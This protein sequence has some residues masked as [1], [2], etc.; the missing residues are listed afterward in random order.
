MET[1]D[2]GPADSARGDKGKEGDDLSKVIAT[3]PATSRDMWQ[4]I[5]TELQALGVP[6]STLQRLVR[7]VA[8][9]DQLLKLIALLTD[10]L[11][12]ASR[13]ATIECERTA[14]KEEALRSTIDRLQ[15]IVA[16]YTRPP[17]E[18]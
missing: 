3:L 6:E 8:F 1:I 17:S 14:E 15:Q 12:A 13:R 11:E 16:T 9:Q 7:P 4:P 5:L 18:N 10:R 2:K